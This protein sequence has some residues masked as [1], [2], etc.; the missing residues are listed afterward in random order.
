MTP[1]PP[2]RLPSTGRADIPWDD[3]LAASLGYA[4]AKRPLFITRTPTYPDGVTASVPAYA[5]GAY[6]CVAPSEDD[7]F[8]WL[9]V[10]VVD[11]LNGKLDQRK[12]TALKHAA[13][14]AWP[15]VRESIR[16]ADGRPFWRLPAEE[17]A[18]RPPPG[19][20]GEA[21]DHAWQECMATGSVKTALTHKLLHHKRPDLFPLIDRKTGRRLKKQTDR[22]R[23]GLWAVVHQELTD[24][25]AQ[26]TALEAAFARLVAAEDDVP[27][28]RL[29]LH[30]ILLWLIAAGWWDHAVS[31]GRATSEWRRWQ[32][33]PDV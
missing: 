4:R 17:A 21:L 3:A 18:R 16:R 29:R 19:S 11:G 14:R 26:F 6:D 2:F 9:D 13:D 12:I 28:T 15:H 32:D 27:L 5:Y 25:D 30:D 8:A 31:H 20:A 1:A 23:V 22:Q 33:D 10:L 24:N 7:E